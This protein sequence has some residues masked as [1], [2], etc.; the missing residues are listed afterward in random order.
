M[1]LDLKR[2]VSSEVDIQLIVVE[3][4]LDLKR[5][6]EAEVVIKLNL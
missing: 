2:E 3:V 1:K 6:V 5:K 4:K